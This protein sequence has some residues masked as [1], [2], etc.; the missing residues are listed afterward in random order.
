MVLKGGEE[1]ASQEQG[2]TKTDEQPKQE[3][4][5]KDKSGQPIQN[6]SPENRGI[7]PNSDNPSSEKKSATREVMEALSNK[8]KGFYCTGIDPKSG[9]IKGKL[10]DGTEF[11][12]TSEEQSSLRNAL[13]KDGFFER[14]Q[15]QSSKGISLKDM[16]NRA[17]QNTKRDIQ[18]IKE[19][20]LGMASDVK[21]GFSL[22]AQGKFRELTGR[23]A[24]R[25]ND[26]LEAMGVLPKRVTDTV[27]GKIEGKLGIKAGEREKRPSPLAKDLG[28]GFKLLR[29]KL[30]RMRGI[31]TGT[32]SENQVDSSNV[33]PRTVNPAYLQR[34]GGGKS[35]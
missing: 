21:K 22:I 4:G 23:V 2:L 13:R 28:R 17:I 19:N 34:L 8:Y 33:Q 5:E 30:A 27:N 16:R 7:E 32:T 35:K 18:D 11:E 29:Q 10:S 26:N 24:L 14:Y 25:L 1:A 31:R 6:R 15:G 12:L 9:E 20:V 3:E